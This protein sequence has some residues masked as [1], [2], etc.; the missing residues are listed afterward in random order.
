MGIGQWLLGALVCAC[1]CVWAQESR[2]DTGVTVQDAQRAAAANVDVS[3]ARRTLA[4]ARGDVAAA[5]HAPAPQLTAKASQMD[6]QN[7]LGGGNLFRDKRIDKSLGLDWT[8]ER[9]NK[10]ELRT[11]TAIAN[12]QAARA[13][14]Q[15]AIVQQQIAAS[16]AFF[17]L[18]A[19]QEKIAQMQALRESADQLVEASQRRVRAGDLSRQE[20]MR[21]EIE[22]ERARTDAQAAQTDRARA[23]LALAQATGLQGQLAATGGWPSLAKAAGARPFDIE[24]RGDVRAARERVLAAQRALEG[25]LALQ[26]T[27]IT[28]GASYDHFPGTS[29]RLL[30]LRLQVPLSGEI[31]YAFQGE[32][33][34]ARAQLAQAEDQLQKVRLAA[35]ADMGRLAQDLDLSSSRAAAYE[36]EIVPRAREVARLAEYAFSRGAMTLAD[37]IDARRTLR[38]V[39]L[40]E[41]AARADHARAIAAWQLRQREDPE[42]ESP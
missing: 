41:I 34:R 30:E 39:L 23:E 2:P 38:A 25:A 5:D 29:T 6:L 4:A 27:D 12:A 13:D 19:A 8:I 18:L 37:L 24:R 1:A 22:A 7:G 28:V 17:D 33:E 16:G 35:A 21:V 15:E 31:G 10:R 9:G 26:H 42:T 14:V 32:I 36:D 11:Q 40:E 20:A 3:I